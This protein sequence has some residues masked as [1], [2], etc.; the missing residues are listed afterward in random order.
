MRP[1]AAASAMRSASSGVTSSVTTEVGIGR[2][3]WRA[4]SWSKRVPA[5][6]TWTF[7]TTTRAT[8]SLA[9]VRLSK[10]TSTSTR[11]PGTTKP[12]TPTTSLTRT[13]IARMPGGMVGGRPAPAPCGGQLGLGDRLVGGDGDDGAAVDRPSAGR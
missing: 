8:L 5:V 7:E 11:V 12:A 3:S 6:S 4:F 13:E 1:S 2:L 9:C 10:V